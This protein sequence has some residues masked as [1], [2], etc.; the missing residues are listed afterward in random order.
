MARIPIAPLPSQLDS[1]NQTV[2]TAQIPVE[3]RS[4]TA[5]GLMAVA[6]TSARI[7]K[8]AAEADDFKNMTQGGMA[9]Q[10]AQMSFAKDQ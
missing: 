10:D 4:A 9:M 8:L 3:A 6:D 2:R 5:E 7:M 1:G